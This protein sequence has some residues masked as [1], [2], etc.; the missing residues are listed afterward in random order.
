[1]TR[2]EL[3]A[4][5]KIFEVGIDTLYNSGK[6]TSEEASLRLGEFDDWYFEKLDTVKWE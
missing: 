4:L 2:N 1:M 6:I 5:K 3:N